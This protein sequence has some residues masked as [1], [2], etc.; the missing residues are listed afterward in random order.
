METAGVDKIVCKCLP[1]AYVRSN[2]G[3]RYPVSVHYSVA[4]RNDLFSKSNALEETAHPIFRLGK[5]FRAGF[6]INEA[7]G[8]KWLRSR[9]C[10]TSAFARPPWDWSL[11]TGGPSRATKLIISAAAAA[12]P[13][14]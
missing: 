12:M 1:V 10:P 7:S 4:A 2:W 3:G 5:N 11:R 9:L 13:V 8:N 6:S 14:R